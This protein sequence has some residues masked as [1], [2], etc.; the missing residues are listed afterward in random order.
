VK[1]LKDVYAG[2]IPF[3]CVKKAT[4]KRLA[5]GILQTER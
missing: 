5:N 4:W 1:N 3:G 2:K